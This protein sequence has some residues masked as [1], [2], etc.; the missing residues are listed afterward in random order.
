MNYVL[1]E[2]RPSN[3]LLVKDGPTCLIRE[4]VLTLGK[5]KHMDSMVRDILV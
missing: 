2:R 4:N 5:N 3:E 1:D